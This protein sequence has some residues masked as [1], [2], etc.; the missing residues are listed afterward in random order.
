M[1]LLESLRQI[2]ATSPADRH[3]SQHRSEAIAP[4]AR[5][6]GWT[7][8]SC[9]RIDPSVFAP[10]NWLIQNQPKPRLRGRV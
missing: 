4:G 3:Q 1:L 10:S 2:A 5:R 6:S 7:G 9:A 8:P